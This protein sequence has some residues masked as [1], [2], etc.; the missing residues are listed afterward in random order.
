MMVMT[1]VVSELFMVI[2]ARNIPDVAVA[3]KATNEVNILDIEF[4]PQSIMDVGTIVIWQPVSSVGMFVN[5]MFSQFSFIC[6]A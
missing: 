3:A 1:A 5:K 2:L 4:L 6:R